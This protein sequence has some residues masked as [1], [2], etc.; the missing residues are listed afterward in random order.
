MEDWITTQEIARSRTWSDNNGFI[1][2]IPINRPSTPARG[3]DAVSIEM[4]A[5]EGAN[6]L[7]NII[8]SINKLL[9]ADIAED[10]RDDAL[11]KL[12]KGTFEQWKGIRTRS[13]IKA[14]LY[15][16]FASET[17]KR[18]EAE[19]ALIFLAKVHY[20]VLTFIRAAELIPIFKSVRCVP[21]HYARPKAN[22]G[23][24]AH[25]HHPMEVSENLGIQVN[26]TGWSKM[27]DENAPKIDDL[28]NEKRKKFHFHAEL[29]TLYYYDHV[30]SLKEQGRTHP[31]MGCSRRNCALCYLFLRGHG[32][33]GSRGTHGS[34][35]H[36]WDVPEPIS[37][38]SGSYP[39]NNSL[40]H[41]LE[42]FVATL[43]FVLQKLLERPC[44]VR[45]HELR[46]QSSKA[47]SSAQF[48][49]EK[50]LVAM[51]RSPRDIA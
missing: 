7:S 50:E 31:Y 37:D 33:F 3:S 40:Q 29:Q 2:H 22:P 49:A 34:I 30:L 10:T 21:F 32:R 26:K 5:S 24:K 13:S 17:K 38:S 12:M 35:L 25:G 41:G 36:R 45:N 19:N 42:P 14:F 28:L 4:S 46:A 11:R 20:S 44:P 43:K 47:L 27:F 23:P 16:N 9:Q 48:L 15:R 18:K 6:D 39:V 1:F 8:E 51:E